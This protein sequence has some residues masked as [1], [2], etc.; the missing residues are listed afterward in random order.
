MRSILLFK[1]TFVSGH[2]FLAC[3]SF[4]QI[5]SDSLYS[6]KLKLSLARIKENLIISENDTDDNMN[7]NCDKVR[8]PQL[9]SI[10]NL[11][12]PEKLH[13]LT[14]RIVA[15]ESLI[16]LG[17]QYEGLRPYLEHL[18][19]NSP[20][21][22]FLHPF[23]MQ[24]IASATDLRK[25]VYMA[26]ASQALD[27]DNTLNLM[28]R[29]NWE[30]TDVM[31]QHSSYVDALLQEVYTLN[32]RL[33]I[34]RSSLPLTDDVYN[35]VWENVA[36]LIAHTLVD[37]FANAKKCSNGG[38]ALMQLDFAQL[39]SKFEAITSLRPM[40]YAEFVELYIKAFYIHKDSLE[41]WIKEHKEYSPKH[42]IGL[43]SLTCQNDKKKRQYL[44]ALIEEQRP[45]R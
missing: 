19:A 36:Y 13:G 6:P 26:V 15:V 8:Q 2:S 25:P 17:Q 35:S 24:T 32:E 31:S 39:K 33:K 42:L 44:I 14:E 45:T 40:P 34:I 18:I 5:N 30:V 7:S 38:R 1:E 3:P 4:Q 10:V 9:S 37:G 23:Y 11:S 21:R 22:G 28:S 27:V 20:Q 12:Q 16:F 43:I 29:V 41:E